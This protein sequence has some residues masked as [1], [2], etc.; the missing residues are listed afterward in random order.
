VPPHKE[1]LLDLVDFSLINE[2]AVRF[3]VGAVNVLAGNFVYFDDHDEEIIP[4]QPPRKHYAR[5]LRFP[6]SKRST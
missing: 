4:K 5:S 2:H 3:A 1:T 6:L